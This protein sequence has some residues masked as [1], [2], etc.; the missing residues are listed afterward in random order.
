MKLFLKVSSLFTL[1]FLIISCEDV[2]DVDVPSIEARLVVD[3]AINWEKG[4]LGNNQEIILSLST[5]YFAGD[6]FE[7]AT[8]AKVDIINLVTNEVFNFT[9]NNNGSY[10]TSFFTPEL[11][12]SYGLSIEYDNQTY[13]AEETFRPVT[14]IVDINQTTDGGFDD[15][16]T[17]VN[18]FFDD[19]VGEENYYLV[20]FSEPGDLL[21]NF[22]TLKDE[23]TNGNQMTIFF[24]KDDD[25]G[26]DGDLL[27]GDIVEIELIGISR[28][29]FN[30][31]SLLLDQS[32]GQGPFATTPS[33]VNGNCINTTNTNKP[34]YGYFRLTEVDK[35]IY[36]VE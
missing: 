4:S 34:A 16:L 23:F 20:K 5:D 6:T 7:P 28:Q 15:S 24:E 13:Y 8:G 27:P 25:D 36:V 31:M 22:I 29:Y 26:V 1:F 12:T 35:T 2:I 10:T 17:E 30:Y 19:P 3:A 9:D 32:E 14:P 18:I 11:N 33:S 21:P